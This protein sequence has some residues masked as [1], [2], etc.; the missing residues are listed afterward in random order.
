MGLLVVAIYE[1]TRVLCFSCS[2]CLVAFMA[3]LKLVSLCL[4]HADETVSYSDRDRLRQ[5]HGSIGLYHPFPR[6]IRSVKSTYC[7]RHDV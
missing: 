2:F 1:V 5:N 3:F 4:V 7:V 6:P